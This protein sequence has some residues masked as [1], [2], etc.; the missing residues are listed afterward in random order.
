MS[1]PPAMLPPKVARSRGSGRW[2]WPAPTSCSALITCEHQTIL[3]CHK[4][5][6]IQRLPDWQGALPWATAFPPWEPRRSPRRRPRRCTPRLR[7]RTGHQPS[8]GNI[9]SR[10]YFILLPFLAHFYVQLLCVVKAAY[11]KVLVSI[12]IEVARPADSQP[13]LACDQTS[14]KNLDSKG[15]IISSGWCPCLP[16]GTRP[17]ISRKALVLSAPRRLM[18]KNT[19]PPRSSRSENGA[20]TCAV[21]ISS[22][23]FLQGAKASSYHNQR[24]EVC[25]SIPGTETH[26][27]IV[28]TVAVCID[29]GERWAKAGA[30]RL[31]GK[32]PATKK[33]FDLLN[34]FGFV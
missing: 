27:E 4:S 32:S 17:R 11:R 12:S 6:Q 34:V 21:E 3:S 18:N 10:E 16:S 5:C 28:A 13:K 30:K 22:Y 7:P 14:I 23:Q 29:R 2:C 25:C 15:E 33:T 8:I 1:I 20:L 9:R 26:Q 24:T 19:A 31:A